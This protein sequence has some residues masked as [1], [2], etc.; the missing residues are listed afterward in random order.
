MKEIHFEWNKKKNEAN[1]KKHGISF[2]EAKSVFYDQNAIEFFD[3]EHSHD[4]QRFLLLGFSDKLRLLII[5]HCFRKSDSR[6]RIISARKATKNE[7]KYY[8]R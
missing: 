5:C 3:E 8:R 7:S 1:L 2:E 4:E 6:I